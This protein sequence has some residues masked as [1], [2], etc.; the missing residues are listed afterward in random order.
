MAVRLG[1]E[2]LYE[3]HGNTRRKC[4]VR[5]GEKF[6]LGTR[7]LGEKVPEPDIPR[8]DTIFFLNSLYIYIL[9]KKHYLRA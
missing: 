6:G 1:S 7:G 8:V 3:N 4:T 2:F 5:L 9:K